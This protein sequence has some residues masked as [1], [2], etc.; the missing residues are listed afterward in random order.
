MPSSGPTGRPRRPVTCGPPPHNPCR[1]RPGPHHQ[2]WARLF[3]LQNRGAVP[4]TGQQ[5]EFDVEPVSPN[6]TA[7]LPTAPGDCA[8]DSILHRVEVQV[9]LLGGQLVAATASQIHP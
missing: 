2:V 4:V 9:E 7:D 1:S 5:R 6:G 3:W 8:A